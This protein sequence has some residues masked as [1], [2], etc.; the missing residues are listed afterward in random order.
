MIRAYGCLF[1]WPMAITRRSILTRQSYTK[2]KLMVSACILVLAQHRFA[3]LVCV[4]RF[5][6][7]FTFPFPSYQWT[8]SKT[9]FLS[10]SRACPCLK[11]SRITNVLYRKL[12]NV[13]VVCTIWPIGEQNWIDTYFYSANTGQAKTQPT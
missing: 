10:L 2:P 7:C 13:N 9:S 12:R 5:R 8:G 6:S 1:L 11:I 4:L 3:L